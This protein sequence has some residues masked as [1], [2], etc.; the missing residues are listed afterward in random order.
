M[1]ATVNQLE[2]YGRAVE[3]CL[4]PRGDAIADIVRLSEGG[5]TARGAADLLDNW[6]STRARYE[7]IWRAVEW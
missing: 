2:A 7:D 5:L 3:E 1:S 6:R 4:L